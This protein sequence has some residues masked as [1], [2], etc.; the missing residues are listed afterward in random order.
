MSST[1]PYSLFFSSGLYAAA[2][3]VYST[4]RSHDEDMDHAPHDSTGDLAY[5][6]AAAAPSTRSAPLSP[7]PRKRRSSLTASASPMSAVKLAKSP[8]RSAGNAWYVANVAVPHSPARSRSGSLNVA[9]EDTSMLGRMRSG[10]IGSRIRT[11]KPLTNKR[12]VAL[13]FAATQPAPSA[14]L[15]PLPLCAPARPP[16]TRLAI[17]LAGPGPVLQ[18]AADVFYPTKS[19]VSP[20][21]GPIDEDFDEMKEN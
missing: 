8:S 16:L 10:S 18:P 3:S 19:P 21:F 9:S 5:F 17:Q 13:L 20:S 7:R 11:K 14:P 15:P 6:P 12:P 2:A 1:S 4:S